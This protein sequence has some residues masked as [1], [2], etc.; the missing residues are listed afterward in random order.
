MALEAADSTG[1]ALR[2]VF[3]ELIKDRGA[4]RRI[5]ALIEEG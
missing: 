3:G 1:E 2:E 5:G 4:A